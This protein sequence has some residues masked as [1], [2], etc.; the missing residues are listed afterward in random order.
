MTERYANMCGIYGFLTKNN[1]L[2][3]KIQHE[4]ATKALS[5]R[6]PDDIQYFRAD[7][8]FLGHTRLSIL[9]VKN[10]K[11]PMPSRSKNSTITYNG[12]IYNT[13]ELR[14]LL[15]SKGITLK[16][17]SDTEVIIELYELYGI[18]RTLDLIDGMFAFGIW[19]LSGF[20]SSTGQTGP[21]P[22]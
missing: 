20:T 17:T 14:K 6:G 8:I 5:H 18:K 13:P 21:F 10:A 7:N 16:T 19:A 12:E 9:D 3:G 22:F 4:E 11:Q 1:G 15:Q 2:L